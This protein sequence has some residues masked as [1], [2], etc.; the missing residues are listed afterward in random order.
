LGWTFENPKYNSHQPGLL[1]IDV[2]SI[3]I[4][5]T[6]TYYL[7]FERKT[8]HRHDSQKTIE[9]FR[10]K[11]ICSH[12]QIF[13]HQVSVANFYQDVKRNINQSLSFRFWFRRRSHS[14]SRQNI[15]VQT[16][17]TSYDR[18]DLKD[19]TLWEQFRK[20][21]VDWIKD[22]FKSEIL[23]IRLTRLRNALRKRDVWVLKDAKMIIAKSLIRILEE[24]HFTFWI[25]EEIVNNAEKFESDVIDHV[26]KIDFDHNLIDYS[27]QTQ[28]RSESQKSES[29]RQ[30]S[31]R[32]R[33]TQTKSVD[34]SL[35]KEK[36]SI[37]QRS[38][39]LQSIRQQS[40]QSVRQ[41]SSSF[42]S[43]DTQISFSIESIDVQSVD[44][45]IR[46]NS[47]IK[48]FL[49]KKSR[50]SIS[51]WSFIESSLRSILAFFILSSSSISRCAL[52]SNS[53]RSS[54]SSTQKK[55]SSIESIKSMT[56]IRIES[57]HEKELANLTKLYTNETKYSDENDSF[58]F[59]LTIFHDMCDLVN[60]SQS[61]K[62]KAF[63]IMLKNLTFDYYY[64]NM[65][66][67]IIIVITFDEVCFS[68][69]NYFENVEYRRDIL[70]KWNNLTLK[71]VMTSNE[72]NSV[73]ECL[74]L[75]IKKSSS[76]AARLEFWALIREIH[77]Q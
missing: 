4:I 74:Q 49:L 36:L 61:A 14:Q 20:E 17:I 23:K 1:W 73:E 71:S 59:K 41:R 33:S 48:F 40:F 11:Q 58:S 39:S 15:F 70:S 67:I 55:K 56:S 77:S 25:E 24:E 69:R 13:V 42:Q 46:W 60:V 47:S 21:F 65:F 63:L 31:L 45:F 2:S 43:L 8:I 57:D 37:R 50:R 44:Q 66:T 26:R 3:H 52:S 9:L 6:S 29:A 68:M 76:F 53:S 34:Q 5:S 72:D 30:S 12:N 64:S 54:I 35:N 28:L 62:L 18:E 10:S 75:L 51:L 38:S 22:D 19:D 32:E 27:W 7:Q 16:A